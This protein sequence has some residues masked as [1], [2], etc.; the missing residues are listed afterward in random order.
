MISHPSSVSVVR[1]PIR[2]AC[3]QKERSTEKETGHNA[4]FSNKPHREAM[5]QMNDADN[6]EQIDDK[7]EADDHG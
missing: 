1:I 5:P 4:F 3:D 6:D 7:D 2:Q